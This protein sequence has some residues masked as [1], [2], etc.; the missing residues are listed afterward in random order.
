MKNLF[1]SAIFATVAFVSN[2]QVVTITGFGTSETYG[3]GTSFDTITKLLNQ[4]YAIPSDNA[5]PFKYEY[6]IDFSSN[7]CLLKNDIGEVV[8]RLKFIVIS[9]YSK[10]EFQIEFTDLKNIYENNFGIVVSNNKAARYESN[11]FSVALTVFDS[12]FIY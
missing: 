5:I 7:T 11:N 9:K 4:P 3:P 2:A 8:D 12:V 6:V 1:L 10:Q